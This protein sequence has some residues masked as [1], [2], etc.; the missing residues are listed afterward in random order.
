[1][2]TRKDIGMMFGKFPH[3]V[4]AVNMI[5]IWFILEDEE[6]RKEGQALKGSIDDAWK[7]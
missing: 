1:M 7:L 6:A 5:D 3:E 2:K 4:D